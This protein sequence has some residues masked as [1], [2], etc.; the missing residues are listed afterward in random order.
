M[1]LITITGLDSATVNSKEFDL[2]I[3][4]IRRLVAGYLRMQNTAAQVGDGGA[5]EHN[6]FQILNSQVAADTAVFVG[7]QDG[8]G[9]ALGGTPKIGAA[10]GGTDYYVPTS[11]ESAHRHTYAEPV[12]AKVNLDIKEAW[13]DSPNSGDI[14][15]VTPKKIKVYDDLDVEDMIDVLV[16]YVGEIAR[17]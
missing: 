10:G 15:L 1:Q 9:A 6:A 14:M 5:H 12:Y 4:P 13:P 17:P 16:E 8:K 7:V 2:V 3:A 11:A